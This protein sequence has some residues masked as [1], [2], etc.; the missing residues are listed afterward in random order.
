MKDI[1]TVLILLIRI[2][3]SLCG[4][5]L[6]RYFIAPF[7][8]LRV[9]NAGNVFGIGVGGILIL[10]SIFW[11][12]LGEAIKHLWESTGGRAFV[13]IIGVAVIAFTSL[14][15]VTLGQ[16]ISHSHYT[17]DNQSV[18]LILG[19][20]IRGSVPSMTLKARCSAAAEYL[21]EHPDAVAIATGGQGADEDLSEGQCI[22]NLLTE[23]GIDG[24]RIFIEDKSTNTDT[25]ISNA[26]EIINDNG[27]STDVAVATSDYHEYRASL[28]CKKNGLNASAVPSA[29][30][31]FAKPTF[32]TR[33][34]FGVWVQ[35]IKLI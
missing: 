4:L 1:S 33:E 26:L 27:L 19:C 30:T 35:W 34:V 14:F 24:D 32:F 2:L 20:Q 12:K 13:S 9:L 23:A 17:A 29:S 15:F 16:I 22:Y 3:I 18:I 8:S 6:I 11:N 10:I 25:N 7:V 5:V 21:K 31:K 28:I